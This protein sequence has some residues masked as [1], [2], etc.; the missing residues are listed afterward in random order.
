MQVPNS[1]QHEC[2]IEREKQREEGDGRAKRAED[3]QEGEDEPANQ[4]ETKFIGKFVL[5]D[6]L[7]G[8]LDLETARSQ[9]DGKGDPEAAVGR[10]CSGTESVAHS[11]FPKDSKFSVSA[12]ARQ[13]TSSA[14]A[15]SAHYE[16][17]HSPHASQQLD[18]STVSK[19]NA[20][21]EIRRTEI[22]RTHVDQTQ[23]ESGQRKSAQAQGRRVGNLAV[24][25]LSV[26]TR[27]EFSSKGRKTFITA[28]SID[29]SQRPVAKPRCGF[30][31]VM[32]LGGHVASG[33][34]HAV[35]AVGLLVD[36]RVLSGS[37]HYG[38]VDQ[39]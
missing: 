38:T 33:I 37:R 39:F 35:T 15:F 5:T 13:R 17:K 21:H 23:D 19:S 27:L 6:T 36:S 8:L 11:H 25:D 26:G 14:E 3:Q 30:C 34:G 22:S 18:Q 16:I 1:Q 2:Q 7:K 28:G 4:V 32:L 29:M 20:H 12:V 31:G 10:Q 9:D 24:L